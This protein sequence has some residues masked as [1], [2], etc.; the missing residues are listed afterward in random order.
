MTQV[1]LTIL[2][3]LLLTFFLT[4][5]LVDERTSQVLTGALAEIAVPN[6]VFD[7]MAADIV[8]KVG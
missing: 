1:V 3:I 7:N 4:L 5:T 8:H 2:V 6:T